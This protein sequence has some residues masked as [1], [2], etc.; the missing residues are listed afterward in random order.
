MNEMI[1]V[2][3]LTYAYTQNSQPALDDVSF[4]I[5]S[6]DWVAIVGHN[7]S[8]KSTLAQALDGLI[9]F[10]LGNIWVDGTKLT[11]Q[12]V[13]TVRSNIGM[14]FQ[15][16][17]N[18]FVGATVE[19][20]VAFGL[21]NMAVPHDEMQARVDEALSEVHMSDFRR[22]QP[23]QLSGGQKQR[24]ALA[25]VIAMQPKIIILDEAT[26]MLDPVGRREILGVIRKL[27]KRLGI[28]VL[29]I[30]HE[31]DETTDADKII[32]LN[33]GKIV[34]T[35]APE[36]IYSHSGLLLKLGLDVPYS[37]RL[38]RELT[39]RHIK[40]PETYFDEEGMVDWLWQSLLKK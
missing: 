16:P 12:S 19:D 32:V 10:K 37:Q 17:D 36:T 25:G 31:I 38:K 1:K 33:D 9:D 29:S 5:S 34:S 23:E 13:W 39:Q 35:G 7:G 4:T 40:T 2:S 28:T 3:H 26:S 20:D 14:I 18:Q 15:N 11:E 24:V 27:K 21:E 8:G 30:T 22:K 6:G